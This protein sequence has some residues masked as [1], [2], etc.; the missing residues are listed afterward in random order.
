MTG[1]AGVVIWAI[2]GVIVPCS[3]RRLVIE[4]TFALSYQ[5]RWMTFKTRFRRIMKPGS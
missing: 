1:G 5:M 2:M 4:A 3:A